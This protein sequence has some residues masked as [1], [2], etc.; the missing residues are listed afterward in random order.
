MQTREVTLEHPAGRVRVE[1]P[2]DVRLEELMP[3]FLDVA[4]QPDRDDWALG[5]AGGPP[6]PANLTL[7]QLGVTEGS[8][9]VLHTA[10]AN[11]TPGALPATRAPAPGDTDASA[12]APVE[13]NARASSPPASSRSAAEHDEA[14]GAAAGQRAHRAHA[15]GPPV[16]R[17]ARRDRRA[18]ARHSH[19]AGRSRRNA[20]DRR[21]SPIRPCS[22]C[23]R[24][25]RR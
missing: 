11:G 25:C 1:V 8:V 12:P 16:D 4:A 21:V 9:L 24:G 7:A 19:P 13:L 18:R 23:P 15:P 22:R 2:T 5:A 17:P 6:Y 10:N 20:R 14:G 3:D